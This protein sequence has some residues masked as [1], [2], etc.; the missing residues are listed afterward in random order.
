ML[1]PNRG[2]PLGRIVYRRSHSARMLM[3]ALRSIILALLLAAS[4]LLA[5]ACSGPGGA[6][7]APAP[8]PEPQ[9]AP[10]TQPPA[11]DGDGYY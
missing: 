3:P 1:A 10:A 5:A 2:G 6:P 9:D 11:D 8:E 7:A 4:G